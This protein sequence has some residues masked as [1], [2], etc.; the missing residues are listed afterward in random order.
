MARVSRRYV[1][2][3]YY[4]RRLLT[5]MRQR[6]GLIDNFH[7]TSN[8]DIRTDLETAGLRLLHSERVLSGLQM[9]DVVLLLEKT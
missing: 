2:V 6:M 4:K 8:D 5:S 9:A 1:V 7:L 3:A